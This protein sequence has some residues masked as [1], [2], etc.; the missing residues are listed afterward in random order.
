MLLPAH[1]LQHDAP[2]TFAALTDGLLSPP[3]TPTR[4]ESPE[5]HLGLP[6]VAVIGT[7]YVGKHLVSAF[8]KRYPVIAY[9]LKPE[10][11]PQPSNKGTRFQLTTTTDPSMLASASVFLISVPTLLNND[12]KT[13][14]T[15]P[16]EK[17]VQN[18]KTYAPKHSV[19]VV[20]SSV[21]VG[22]TR[23]LFSDLTLEPYNM[24]V[25]MSPERVDP[26]RT[27][28]PFESIPKIISGLDKRALNSI[29]EIYKRV[30][31]HLVPVT[32]TEVAELTKLYENSQRLMCI[33]FANEMA[34]ACHEIGI[35]HHEVSKAASTKPFGFL[36]IS[37][38][39]GVGGHC[40]PVNPWYLISTSKVWSTLE[41]A[42]TKTQSR[43]AMLASRLLR[44]LTLTNP[45]ILVVGLAFKPGQSLTTNSPGVAY[46][47]ALHHILTL[48]GRL[49]D[50]QYYDPLVDEE[51]SD[52]GGIRRWTEW[53]K[54]RLDESFDVIVVTMKQKGIDY[55][56][57]DSLEKSRVKVVY[58]C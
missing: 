36:P 41:F 55:A 43:P 20:E 44:H 57:L 11:L 45:R 48:R 23:S 18:L 53:R 31:D 25:G 26:G 32:K 1:I 52:V 9:D 24:L 7:G 37:A 49:F 22:M 15:S 13:I 47:T 29:T 27:D 40:L 38:G 17:T 30:F 3:T 42:T 33:T 2:N 51:I 10:S 35:D 6:T 56:V 14:N 34:D 39:A 12:R 16:L 58:E 50:L 28:P 8:N 19:V 54:T 5:P 46:A 4:L 21:A